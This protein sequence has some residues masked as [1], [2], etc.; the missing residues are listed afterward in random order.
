MSADV[1]RRRETR[2][3]YRI[4][5]EEIG[6]KIIIFYAVISVARLRATSNCQIVTAR[7]KERV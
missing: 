3:A 2:D 6:A 1:R 5:P 7:A 4:Q